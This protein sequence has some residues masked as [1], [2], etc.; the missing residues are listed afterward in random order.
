MRTFSTASVT[1][2][3]GQT[4]RMSSSFVHQTP[5][6]GD[7]T[8]EHRERL[9]GVSSTRFPSRHRHMVGPDRGTNGPMVSV[10][11]V[12]KPSRTAVSGIT[13]TSAAH[14][15]PPVPHRRFVPSDA[16]AAN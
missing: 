10:C 6:L 7:Q 12:D 1:Q 5:R 16:D 3:S 13:I 9:L 15:P 2:T 8:D 4:V 11:F 14:G